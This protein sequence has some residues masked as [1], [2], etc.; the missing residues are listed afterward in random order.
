MAANQAAD[1]LQVKARL[2]SAYPTPSGKLRDVAAEPKHGAE[3]GLFYTSDC[4]PL[5][6]HHR[7]H[8][9]KAQIGTREMSARL[10]YF[11]LKLQGRHRLS[12]VQ[13]STAIETILVIRA[14][15]LSPP[16]PQVFWG[17]PR[18]A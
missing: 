12:L 10:H 8:R 14:C 11:T 17:L 16:L 2:P 1:R 18:L 4:G 3:C 15:E 7:H 13:S 5:L 9:F 6:L